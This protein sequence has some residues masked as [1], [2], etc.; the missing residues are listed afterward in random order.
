MKAFVS[1]FG[2]GM[3]MRATRDSVIVDVV[4]SS[5]LMAQM[6]GYD[7]EQ[8]VPAWD[9]NEA[10]F[11]GGHYRDKGKRV[12]MTGDYGTGGEKLDLANNSVA[13]E[14]R[15]RGLK[16]STVI[17]TSMNGV[18]GTLLAQKS[19]SGSNIYNAS[20]GNWRAVMDYI[21]K[22][23]RDVDIIPMGDFGIDGPDDSLF[24]RFLM[25][26]INGDSLASPSQYV[27]LTRE[28]RWYS[29]ELDK[30]GLYGANTEQLM[31]KFCSIGAS[32]TDWRRDLNNLLAHEANLPVVPVVRQRNGHPV[33]VNA[34][35]E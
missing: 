24:A 31:E 14:G 28:A 32:R 12:F 9:A 7:I 6:L 10:I 17:Q 4:R 30:Y 21:R 2:P 13:I 35:K 19:A 26:R 1:H 5:G 23:G 15:A 16:G 25:L 34:L 3:A 27:R 8:I 11:L 29:P 18:R 22:Q 20:W 33:I